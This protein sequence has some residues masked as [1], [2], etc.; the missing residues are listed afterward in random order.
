M[1]GCNHRCNGYEHGQTPE[2]GE[3]QGGLACYVPQD[4]KE[5]DTTGQQ[6]NRYRELQSLTSHSYLH[7]HQ[8]FV[9]SNLEKMT[10]LRDLFFYVP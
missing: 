1:A 4:H 3:G 10:Y 2:D 6:N 8:I 5:S 9:N 7:L